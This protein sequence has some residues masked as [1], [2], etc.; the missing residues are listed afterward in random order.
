MAGVISRF[1]TWA[2]GDSD[3]PAGYD[4]RSY[5]EIKRQDAR[6][7]PIA[8][9]DRTDHP[10]YQQQFPRRCVGTC[11]PARQPMTH[12]GQA[13]SGASFVAGMIDW[14]RLGP[15]DED[16]GAAVPPPMSIADRM[17]QQALIDQSYASDAAL[18]ERLDQLTPEQRAVVQMAREAMLNG[19]TLDQ[20][21][22]AMG[23]KPRR[24]LQPV[25]KLR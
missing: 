20:A 23:F 8:C 25:R 10:P 5:D 19:Q 3:P 17:T 2:L 13:M 18:S 15:R 6:D 12:A 1:I 14:S 24:E 4:T 21:A 16:E 9:N 11:T 22:A 7:N